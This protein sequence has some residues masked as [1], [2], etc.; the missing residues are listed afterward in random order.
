[1]RKPKTSVRQAAPEDISAYLGL[2]AERWRDDNMASREQLE[3]RLKHYPKGMFVAESEGKI[4]GMV[5]AMRLSSYDY[6]ASPSWNTLTHN[7][8]CDNA[9]PDG[10][11]IFGVDLSTARGVGAAAGDKLLLRIG[12]LVIEEGIEVALLGGRLPGYHEYA[13]KMSAESYLRAKGPD[14]KPL[15]R[16]VA[17]YTSVPGMQALKVLPNYFHDPESLDYGV[18]LRWKNPFFGL[19]GRKLWAWLLPKIIKI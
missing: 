16:Q 12:M 13:D 10:R 5:F 1:M 19:P 14:G 3:T 9:D 15:D 17:F 2:Q 7:G 18:L 6:G 8:Y 4:V 11:V